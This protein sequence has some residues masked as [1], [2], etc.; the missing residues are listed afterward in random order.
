MPPV[1]GPDRGERD[2]DR[3]VADDRT[4]GGGLEH[5]PVHLYDDAADDAGPLV[6]DHALAVE[7]ADERRFHGGAPRPRPCSAGNDHHGGSPHRR[8]PP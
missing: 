8:E 3:V 4:I 7:Q 6:V 2:V 1:V 5:G